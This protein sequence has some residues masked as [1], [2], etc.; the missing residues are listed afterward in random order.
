MR[1]Q[2]AVLINELKSFGS[3]DNDTGDNTSEKS[4]KKKVKGEDGYYTVV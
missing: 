1:E 2:N 4:K 3:K